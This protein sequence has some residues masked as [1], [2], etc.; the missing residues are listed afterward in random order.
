MS[1][2]NLLARNGKVGLIG[3]GIGILLSLIYLVLIHWNLPGEQVLGILLTLVRFV[4]MIFGLIGFFKLRNE[5][6]LA[7]LA[8]LLLAIT[9]LLSPYINLLPDILALLSGWL[10]FRESK[11][12]LT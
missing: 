3:G 6:S 5:I 1:R 12:N 11:K 7:S 4:I 8:Q 2:K 9:F 10:S